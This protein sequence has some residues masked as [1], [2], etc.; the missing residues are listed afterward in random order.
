MSMVFASARTNEFVDILFGRA[1]VNT[2]LAAYTQ[3]LLVVAWHFTVFLGTVVL[4]DWWLGYG[5]TM[6]GVPIAQPFSWDRVRGEWLQTE[7]AI[8]LLIALILEGLLARL[9][10]PVVHHGRRLNSRAF[11]RNWWRACACGT[12]VI[13]LLSMAI[14]GLSM[15]YDIGMAGLLVGLIL[16][17]V[18]PAWLVQD[19]LGHQRMARWRPE[20]PECGYSLRGLTEPRCPECGVG[21]PSDS[22]TFRRW[23][24]RR[25]P[26]DR[27]HRGGLFAYLRSLARVAFRPAS[28]ARSLAIPDRWGRSCVWASVHLLLAAVLL[29]VAG[30][31]QEYVRSAVQ[32]IRPPAFQPPHLF[33]FAG[34][35]LGCVAVWSVQSFALWTLALTAPVGVGCLLSVGIPGRHRAAKLGGAKWSLYL[36]PFFLLASAGW[37]TL[38]ELLGRR[39]LLAAP[40]ALRPAL[41]VSDVPMI[42]LIGG[43]GIWRALGM[44][45][46]PYR[47]AY[48]RTT[49]FAY[50]A[51][52]FAS[53]LLVA[54]VLFAPGPLEAVR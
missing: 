10:F 52:F 41:Q 37:Y 51:A 42:L 11:I 44:A 17:M 6:N 2:R 43:Y 34:P 24:V 15:S 35:P 31:R 46:N 7:P 21:F 40:P 27:A 32:Q 48:K 47:R 16:L 3:L 54:R 13:P 36:A 39:L 9:V 33:D 19:E 18:G 53:W 29:M 28:A 1:T 8:V 12:I 25:L 22:R 14:A 4:V 45:A 5:A 23:A 30:S 20:C 38:Y 49:L 50:A 26:W